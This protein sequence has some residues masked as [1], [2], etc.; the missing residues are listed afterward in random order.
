MNRDRAHATSK[1]Q[2]RL[3]CRWTLC[4][5]ITHALNHLAVISLASGEGLCGHLTSCSLSPLWQMAKHIYF[6]QSIL[7]Q[8]LNALCRSSFP[9]S[10][11]SS[12]LCTVW[13]TFCSLPPCLILALRPH[14][15]TPKCTHLNTDPHVHKSKD[16][17]W[18]PWQQDTSKSNEMELL[19]TSPDRQITSSY[20]LLP[21][22]WK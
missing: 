18:V 16:G 21:F 10:D 6:S 12:S 4:P 11:N 3:R 17:I 2:S 9:V 20:P 19:P 5:F 8:S 22:A 7:P 1:H 14:I 15:H 13:L